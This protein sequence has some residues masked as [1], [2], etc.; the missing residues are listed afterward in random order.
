MNLPSTIANTAAGYLLAPVG[1]DFELNSV[2]QS[3]GSVATVTAASVMTGNA[4]VDLVEQATAVRYPV[5]C[6]LLREVE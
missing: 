1:M 2:A 4:S 3:M 6:D 5:F